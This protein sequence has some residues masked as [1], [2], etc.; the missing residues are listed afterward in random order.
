MCSSPSLCTPNFT[1]PNNSS[2]TNGNV[3]VNAKTSTNNGSVSTTNKNETTDYFF[4]PKIKHS[5]PSSQVQPSVQPPVHPQA[6]HKSYNDS[7]SSLSSNLSDLTIYEHGHTSTSINSKVRTD[8]SLI[9][10]D[11]LV[12]PPSINSNSHTNPFF[13]SYKHKYNTSLSANSDRSAHLTGSFPIPTIHQ[14]PKATSAIES[15]FPFNSRIRSVSATN[16]IFTLKKQITLPALSLDTTNDAFDS[17]VK[18]E[19]LKRLNY[20]PTQNF[21]PSI[22]N[23]LP[24]RINYHT[25]ELI[26]Q[27]IQLDSLNNN[28]NNN[29]TTGGGSNNLIVDIRPF[30]DFV[31]SHITGALNIC[32]P[33]TLLKRANFTLTRCI[34]SLPDYE[35]SRFND[36]INDPNG[37]V[38]IVYDSVNNSSNLFHFLNKFVTSP[39]FIAN[40]KDNV[41]LLDSN[42][43]QFQ[44]NYP[45]LIESGSELSTVNSPP[46]NLNNYLPPIIVTERSRS[47]S[48]AEFSSYHRS[49]GITPTNEYSN[50]TTL[51]TPNPYNSSIT[52]STP[53]LATNFSLPKLKTNFKIR[54][55][56]ELL[57][58]TDSYNLSD[59]GSGNGNNNN[60]F[61]VSKTLQ[62]N[63][64]NLFKLS[65]IPS[66]KSK[67]PDWLKTSV[68]DENMIESTRKINEDFS[69]L[70]RFEQRRLLHALSLNKPLSSTSSSST[71]STIG[72]NDLG[73]SPLDEQDDIPPTISC[74][75]EYGHKNRYKDIFLYEHSRVK[76]KASQSPC[77]EDYINASYLNPLGNIDEALSISSSSPTKESLSELDLTQLKYIATQGPLEETMGDFWKCII[78]Q[79]VPLILSLTDEVENGL[80]KCSPFWKSGVYISDKDTIN[81]KLEEEFTFSSYLIIRSFQISMNTNKDETRH[82]YVLQVHVLNWPDMGTMLAPLDLIQVIKL[83]HYVLSSI[84][85]TRVSYPTAIHCSAGC[86]RTGTLCTIDTM[87]KLLNINNDGYNLKYDPV[88]AIVNN[89]RKQRISMVQNLRQYYL[90]YEVL[91]N[92]VSEEDINQINLRNELIHLPIISDFIREFNN[93]QLIQ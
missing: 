88:Y 28:N 82:H 15:N 11:T 1:F 46:S 40:I 71:K 33:S 69:S 73:L 38:L 20:L 8:S 13:N 86:G 61:E 23:L 72:P 74:G 41:Y 2:S 44:I 53:I 5:L 19:Q 22:E 47:Q 78:N 92:F 18:N 35:K 4:S 79:N 27:Q 21:K 25:L 43:N 80:L 84:N 31:K 60:P 83:K 66:D 36:F 67:L 32:L 48:L 29:N 70:E 16:P 52:A 37:G 3:N 51:S 42:F 57:S 93:S 65:N 81:V 39:T 75:I 55:N 58:S 49:S 24:T 89:F 17:I 64:N 85:L 87:I 26:S 50:S 34:N 63:H 45:E 54:H 56:E 77:I 30:T 14:I 91:L 90:I 9:S 12:E 62:T 6:Q 68:L 76:L 10:T 7:I 59:R